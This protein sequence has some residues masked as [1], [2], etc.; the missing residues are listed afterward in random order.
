LPGV[1]RLLLGV[2]SP[3][4]PLGDRAPP[5][6]SFG[7]PKGGVGFYSLL[8]VLGRDHAAKRIERFVSSL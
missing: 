2:S 8:R 3:E 5:L 6:L 4:S 1:V 7:S